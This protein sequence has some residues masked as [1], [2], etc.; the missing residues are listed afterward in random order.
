MDSGSYLCVLRPLHS[1]TL[2]FIFIF[3]EGQSLQ[4]LANLHGG[5]DRTNEEVILEREEI[6]QQVT[7]ALHA[8]F[9]IIKLNLFH[10]CFL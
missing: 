8:R 7:I 9:L 10:F 2:I 4:L 5:G 6:K 1:L 3:S